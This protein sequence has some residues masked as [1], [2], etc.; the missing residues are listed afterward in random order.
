MCDSP[1]LYVAEIIRPTHE[2]CVVHH[3]MLACVCVCVCSC[4]SSPVIV[5]TLSFPLSYQIRFLTATS[6]QEKRTQ[7]VPC[8]IQYTFCAPQYPYIPYTTNKADSYLAVHDGSSARGTRKHKRTNE[9][10]TF[11]FLVEKIR[12]T[13]PNRGRI[14]WNTCTYI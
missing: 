4:P 2:H 6:N 13:T 14:P 10:S 11:A 3:H 9:E 12:M 1:I 7:N 8:S 5:M